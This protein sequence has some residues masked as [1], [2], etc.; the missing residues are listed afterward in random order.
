MLG[1]DFQPETHAEL[2]ATFVQYDKDKPWAEQS[3]VHDRM[4]LWSR[5]HFKT[6][7]VIV[8]IIQ[9]IL[10]FPNLRLIIMQGSIQV[11]KTLLRQ[12]V[13]HFTGEAHGS[14]LQELFPEFC[15]DKKALAASSMSFTTPARVMKQLA[16]A[17][18]TV[19]SPRS[20][21]TGQHYDGGYFDDLVNDQN[22]RNPKLIQKLQG[23]FTL[24]QALIDPGGYRC[25]SGTRYAFGDLYEQIQRWQM[26][27]GKWIISIKDC[28][29]DATSS[30]PDTEKIPRLPRFKKRNGQLGGFTTAELLQMQD[31]DPQNFANQYLNR[32]IALSQQ[33]FT[34]E[35]FVL[36]SIAAGD[37]PGLSA[38]IL[39]CDLAATDTNKSDDNVIAE[40]RVDTL[41]VGYLTGLSGG[42][43]APME[44][45]HRIIDNALRVRPT[46]ILFEGSS[47]AKYFVDFLRLIAK[48][49]NVY[50]PIEE[51]KVDNRPDAK[52]M[53]VTALAGVVKRGRFRFLKGLA[54]MEKLVEQACSF[55]KG[56]YGHD[57]YIDTTSL[58]Y[59]E[60]TKELLALP[61]RSTNSKNP[62]LALMD[63]RQNA[64]IKRL[65]GAQLLEVSLPDQT[66]LEN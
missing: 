36:A 13:T 58:L 31:D 9:A 30:L 42:Q 3:S 20:V 43:W 24:A 53:R 5:G 45:A 2:F 50:L 1:F 63:D 64:L 21:K 65:S 26:T 22:F 38:P 34:P 17:T 7:A 35:L 54:H 18:V 66:G 52:N 33:H 28:W 14:R 44:M 16:Q 61:A 12:I 32:P 55:P 59:K 48:Q 51:I 27:S 23:D 56:R 11:T 62:I 39:V 37:A 15:G 8:D 29:T 46:K 19:A 6:T 25:I 60:L 10:N 40:G 57:D 41:G 49:K 4:I 47:A